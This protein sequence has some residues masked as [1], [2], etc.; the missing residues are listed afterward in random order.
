MRDVK[1]ARRKKPSHRVSDKPAKQKKPASDVML[2]KPAKIAV[3]GSVKPTAMPVKLDGSTS[4]RL[5][6]GKVKPDARIDLH[7]LTQAQAH[8]RL[9]TF[10]RR[11]A[12]RQLRCV[13]VV[14]GKGAPAAGK[15]GRSERFELDAISKSGVL[16]EMVP[17]W[18]GEADLRALVSGSLSAHARH[19]G[20]GALYVYLRRRRALNS[21]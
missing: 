13:L 9:V 20:E 11:C 4:E 17:R 1:L 8:L 5:R 21:S 10:V 6:K 2:V 15:P 16:R 19:G 12:E 3:A 18:L 7:G 14:T